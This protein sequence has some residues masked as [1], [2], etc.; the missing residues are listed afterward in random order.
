MN[1]ICPQIMSN[2][3]IIKLSI[4]CRQLSA[5]NEIFYKVIFLLASCWMF[6]VRMWGGGGLCDNNTAFA[7]QSLKH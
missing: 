4:L 5:G 6:E 7:Y 1:L 2:Y 3:F